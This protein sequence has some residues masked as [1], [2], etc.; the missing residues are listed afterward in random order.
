M[1][2]S[3]LNENE[4]TLD[5][6][7]GGNSPGYSLQNNPLVNF[8]VGLGSEIG[9][10]G[11]GLG[12]AALK[13]AAALTKSDFLKRAAENVGMISDRL[14]TKPFQEQLKT[15]SGKAGQLAGTAA[16]F[17]APSKGIVSA[18]SALRG[19]APAT[20]SRALNLVGRTAARVVPEAIGSG[21]VELARTGGDVGA[22]KS[23]GTAA[24]IMSGAFGAVGDVA[25]ASFWPDLTKSVTR[26]LGISG[27]SSGGRVLPEVE[28]KIAGL[29]VIKQMAPNLKV[30]DST[31][32]EK[33]FDPS[34]AT[35]SETLQAWN[36]ARKS[37]YDRY[38]GLA[39][40]AGES[41]AINIAPIIKD[42]KEVADSPVTSDY[43]RAAKSL[44]KDVVDNFGTVKDKAG[45]KVATFG[46]ADIVRAE[47][48]L[49][50]INKQAAG[51]LA[52]RSD[53]A[54]TEVAAGVA[55]RLRQLLDDAIEGAT[56]E[57]YLSI[58]SE[59]GALKSIENELVSRYKQAARQLGGGLSDYMQI[60]NSGDIISSL[61]TLDPASFAVGATRGALT[62]ARKA[63]TRPDRYLQ[64]SFNLIDNDKINPLVLR[65]FGGAGGRPITD[66]DLRPNG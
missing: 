54:A 43:K 24:G 48:F 36:Q 20:G 3:E 46:R 47:K 1:K 55:G 45:K 34:K 9:K 28:K 12:Q 37:V 31:G 19:L 30:V 40:K 15:T 58:R 14:Y 64:R 61:V 21:A 33:A 5:T 10:T 49:E 59:Y 52:G 42:L 25:R 26:A 44:F 4:Y 60:V 63:L 6:R 51:A 17:I 56:G 11:F 62:A 7:S 8:G 35:F 2:L 27:K 13:G 57:N 38:H 41:T 65:L 32:V 66:V 18:Q 50:S 29:S 22:A 39:Q 23:A 53:K 16:S